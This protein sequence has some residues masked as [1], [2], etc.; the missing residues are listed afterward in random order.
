M[1]GGQ[2]LCSEYTADITS[3]VS[4]C[5]YVGVDTHIHVHV[6]VCVHV[7]VCTQFPVKGA[8]VYILVV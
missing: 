2:L 1:S 8:V 7:H 3:G 4:S 5:L 6:C